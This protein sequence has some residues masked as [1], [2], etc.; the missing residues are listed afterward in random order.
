MLKVN[1]LIPRVVSQNL[2]RQISLSSIANRSNKLIRYDDPFF[3]M[4]NNLMRGLEQE[5]DYVRRQMNRRF[6]MLDKIWD[7]NDFMLTSPSPLLLEPLNETDLILVDKEGNRRFQ[8]NLNLAGFAPEE[9]NV[10]TKGNCLI[11][12]AKKEIKVEIFFKILI[13]FIGLTF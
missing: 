6:N 9:V 4:A 7:T 8:M 5:F 12:S 1:R 10:K 2:A 13:Q 11:V 3:G